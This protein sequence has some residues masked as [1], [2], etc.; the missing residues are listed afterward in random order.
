M[1]CFF[2][3]NSAKECGIP[4]GVCFQGVFYLIFSFIDVVK[5]ENDEWGTHTLNVGSCGYDPDNFNYIK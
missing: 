2:K 5:L 4:L 3:H 1:E